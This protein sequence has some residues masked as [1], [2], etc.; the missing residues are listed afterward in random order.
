MSAIVGSWL[1]ESIAAWL[2]VSLGLAVLVLLLPAFALPRPPGQPPLDRFWEL[3]LTGLI[4]W[5]VT[6]YGLA[7][8]HDFELLTLVPAAA[9]ALFAARRWGRRARPGRSG[10]AEAGTA[11]R[12]PIA[13]PVADDAAPAPGPVPLAGL[14]L[15]ALDPGLPG[16]LVAGAGRGLRALGRGLRRTATRLG[17]PAGAAGALAV[18]AAFA[19]RLGGPLLQVS[20]G[21]PDTYVHL[22]WTNL[23][24]HSRLF[25]QGVYPEGMHAVAAVV[26]D[27]FFVDPLNVLRFLGPTDG[28]LLVLAVYTLALELSGN[29]LGAAVAAAVFGLGTA[30]PLPEAAWRQINPLPQELGA[31]FVPLG[32]AFA[33]RHLRQGD[34]ASLLLVTASFMAGALIHPYSPAFA[35][36]TV[37]CLVLA[38][39]W[40]PGDAR[41]RGVPL[42]AAAAGGT[43]LGL[44]PILAGRLAGIP[45]YAS[46]IRF[47]QNPNSGSALSPGGLAALIR[48]NP[49]LEAGLIFA[50]GAIVVSAGRRTPEAARPLW[51]GFGLAL[52]AMYGLMAAALAGAPLIPEVARTTEFFSIILVPVAAGLL[53][54]G[55][56]AA[57]EH[58]VAAL[59]LASALVLPALALWPPHFPWPERMEPPGASRAF[60]DIRNQFTVR[61]WTI[62]APVQQYSETVGRGWHVELSDFVRRFSLA[63]ASDPRFLLLNAGTGAILTPDVF[64]YV[65]TTP[66]GTNRPLQASDLLLPLPQA[67]G[68]A[69]YQGR[70]LVAIEA[71]AYAWCIAYLHSHPSSASIY[72]QNRTFNV[73][74]IHQP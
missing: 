66:L 54:G 49:Y 57:P 22:L 15:E 47:V 64:I 40:T 14:L 70:Q 51:R 41:R 60:L 2:R 10:T 55:T 39:A 19:L 67:A 24:L 11:K 18:A 56:L 50:L 36:L 4:F 6:V 20:P 46:S 73:F 29:R 44:L 52:A 28:L 34:R 7:A 58:R 45:F 13:G 27:V 63:E 33:V 48:G 71:R 35:G 42:L 12:G 72:Y 17:D 38:H 37:G 21:A 74:H 61:Q 62:V 16:R 3:L 43:L 69:V 23:L 9:L 59:A 31:V 8:I 1:G 25:P 68:T 26:A 5:I 30:S 53:F 65:E 32:I